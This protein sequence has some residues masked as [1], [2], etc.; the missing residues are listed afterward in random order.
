MTWQYEF[1]VWDAVALTDD[2]GGPR[3]DNGER[4]RNWYSVRGLDLIKPYPLRGTF[5]IIHQV[6][7][8][9]VSPY[10]LVSFDDWMDDFKVTASDLVPREVWERDGGAS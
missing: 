8:D 10:Y 1:K 7:F 9:G 2:Y 3:R 6:L 4:T 5:G